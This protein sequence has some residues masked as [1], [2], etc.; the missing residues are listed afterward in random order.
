[1][2]KVG[3]IGHTGRLGKPLT[4]ILKSH[5]YAELIYTESRKE[6]SRGNLSETELVFLA[7]P[8]GESRNYLPKLEGK[9]IIDLSID[10]RDRDNWVYGISELN[11][12]RI[13]TAEKIANPGCYATSI[14]LG[15]VPIKEKLSDV[16]ISSTSGISGAGI[17]VEEEDNFLIYKD[18]KS[19]PQIFEIERT[20]NLKNILFVPQRIDNSERGI[21]SV[22]FAKYSGEKNLNELYED[23]YRDNF[24]V[25]IR[26]RIQ[27]KEVNKTNFCDIKVSAFDDR[28]LVISALDN[29]IKG[30]AGQAVQNFNL[31]YGFDE[32]TGL[33]EYF[34][35]SE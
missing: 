20:L 28:V 16:Q 31:M 23:F 7:L 29:I 18:G 26:D 14:I 27:T 17:D 32:K 34:G 2:V 24:F 5:P 30:G 12:K 6:G 35:N 4:E 9:R 10:H 15:L 19:H 3:V 11:K 25:R 13:T 33:Y 21:V 22:I 1:M 8:Y